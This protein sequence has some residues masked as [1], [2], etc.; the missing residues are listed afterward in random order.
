MPKIRAPYASLCFALSIIGNITD[1]TGAAMAGV[2]V[3]E[4]MSRSETGWQGC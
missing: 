1:V 3:F 4:F 2:E